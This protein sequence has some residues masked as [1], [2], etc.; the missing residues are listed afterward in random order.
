MPFTVTRNQLREAFKEFGQILEV[1]MLKDERSGKLNRRGT[2]LF[3]RKLSCKNA[4]RVMDKAKF[5]D[6][7]V[8]VEEE[9]LLDPDIQQT[10]GNN[11]KTRRNKKN[12]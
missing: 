1:N 11:M 2:I 3:E 5:N 6:R 12:D 10:Y 8:W 9:H 7:I 4:V